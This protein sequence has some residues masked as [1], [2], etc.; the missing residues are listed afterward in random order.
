MFKYR[1][2]KVIFRWLGDVTHLTASGGLG[3][4]SSGFDSRASSVASAGS[5]VFWYLL[6]TTVLSGLV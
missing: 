1:A 4:A 5:A 6:T 2:V 3:S